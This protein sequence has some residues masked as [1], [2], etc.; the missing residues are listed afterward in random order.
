[1]EART[2]RPFSFYC[3]KFTILTI[4]GEKRERERLI[5]GFAGR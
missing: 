4:V 2:I 1:M 3:E 5:N